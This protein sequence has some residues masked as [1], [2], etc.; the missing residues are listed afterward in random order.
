MKSAKDF[1]DE[2]LVD[3]DYIHFFDILTSEPKRHIKIQADAIHMMIE[4]RDNEHLKRVTDLIAELELL[5]SAYANDD[6][7]VFLTLK[8]VISYI[9]NSFK[10]NEVSKPD[11]AMPNNRLT[12]RMAHT[13]NPIKGSSVDRPRVG[14]GD[15]PN[16]MDG[17]GDRPPKEWWAKVEELK[18]LLTGLETIGATKG[19]R[20][21]IQLA[22]RYVDEV[23]GSVTK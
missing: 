13:K 1:V 17:S 21:G 11:V 3:L 2:K 7:T 12:D 4:A 19:S 14:G 20:A 22:L 9:K 18:L 5:A 23:F 16:A 6:Q 15:A 8:R 10:I